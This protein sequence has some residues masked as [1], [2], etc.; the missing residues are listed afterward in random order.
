MLEM[1]DRVIGVIAADGKH[2]NVADDASDL[3]S[4][5]NLQKGARH[6]PILLTVLLFLLSQS[7][8]LGGLF[9]DNVKEDCLI[10]PG[11]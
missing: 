8:T 10:S 11:Q 7:P 3:S 1:A 4:Q 2:G 6:S 5:N 9:A